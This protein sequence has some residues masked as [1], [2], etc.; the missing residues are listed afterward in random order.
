MLKSIL[1]ASPLQKRLIWVWLTQ[2][3]SLFEEDNY[4]MLFHKDSWKPFPPSFYRTH[5]EEEIAAAIDAEY[6]ELN[7]LSKMIEEKRKEI[8][9]QNL[10]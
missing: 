5:T 4:Y 8:H 7:E 6:K 9:G 1:T 2:W 10:N 3:Y